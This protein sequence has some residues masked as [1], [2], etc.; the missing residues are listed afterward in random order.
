MMS[1]MWKFLI[2]VIAIMMIK[3]AD[4]TIKNVISIV[5]VPT[6]ICN[7]HCVYCYH[8]PH[9]SSKKIM[10]FETLENIMKKTIPYYDYVNFLWHGGEP[11]VCGV[12]FYKKV[13]ELE[14]KYNINDA[15]IT[16]KMQTN[17]TLAK[18]E[19]LDYLISQNFQFGTSFDGVT[20]E[21][22]RGNS[23]RILEGRQNIIDKNS[24]CSCI[25][26]ITSLN[27]HKMIENY[28]FFNEKGINYK[29]NHYI[30]TTK[31]EIGNKLQ[32]DINEYLTEEKKL[33]DYWLYDKNCKIR[34]T[35]FFVFL[36]YILFNRKILGKYNSC[37]GKWIGIRYNGDIVQ[38]NRYNQSFYGNINEVAK[39]D[40]AFNSVGFTKI[41]ELAVARRN[42]C[43]KFCDVYDFCRG[44]CIVEASHEKGIT[45]L[46]GFSCIETK[47]MYNYILKKINYV[48]DNYS[49]VKE[50]L[51]PTVVNCFNQYFEKI[52][53]KV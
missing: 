28:K 41:L 30:N 21:L 47:E 8:V 26:V 44:G 15:I 11:L 3:T 35:S 43:A 51:N 29:F 1:T 49:T 33:F 39:I 5:I 17:C 46:N 18:G 12:E 31:D 22:T 6:D 2:Y 38:C 45:E 24:K 23:T 34:L 19:I 25:S 13:V 40:D 37:L 14:K 10:A 52:K 48:R 4:G 16:N 20:N 7:M 53:E 27:V 50:Q 36:E 9:Y 42:K 32:L